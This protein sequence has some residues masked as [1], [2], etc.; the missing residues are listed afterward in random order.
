VRRITTARALLAPVFV[1]ACCAPSLAQVGDGVTDDTLAIQAAIDAVDNAGGGTVRLPKGVYKI[2]ATLIVNRSSTFKTI[3]L[4]GEGMLA[5]RILWFGPTSGA[6]IRVNGLKQ[7]IFEGWSLENR[8]AKGTTVGLLVQRDSGTGTQSGSCSWRNIGVSSFETGI[9]IGN[10]TMAQAGSEVL[11]DHLLL[12]RNGTA[13]LIQDGNSLNFVFNML[14]ME[15]NGTGLQ[16]L[17]GGNVS[18]HGGSASHDTVA[19]FDLRPG[20]VFTIIGFRSEHANRF[21]IGG[22][23]SAGMGMTIMG[24]EVQAVSNPDGFGIVVG[25]GPIVMLSNLLLCKVSVVSNSWCSDVAIGNSVADSVPFVVS[26][27]G[28]HYVQLGNRQIDMRDEPVGHFPDEMGYVSRGMRIPSWGAAAPGRLPIGSGTDVTK[29][30]SGTATWDPPRLDPGA[31]TTTTVSV[32]GASSGDTVAV[33]FS[34]DLHAMQLTGYVSSRGTV[35]VVLRNGTDAAID[36]AR[37]SLR[38]DTWQH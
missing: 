6:A 26:G 21:L 13:C 33:G 38:A 27:T 19:D 22:N 20:G 23:T 8:V 16:V 4:V 3:N 15:A 31:Q 34:Q 36:L 17:S 5:T 25:G 12:T 1:I 37:G 29:H 9:Q 18:V 28:G 7:Y 35:T 30:L 11:F 14:E 2:T 32:S 24:C 10:S